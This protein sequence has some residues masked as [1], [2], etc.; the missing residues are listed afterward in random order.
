[1]SK[2]TVNAY[3]KIS[4]IN[5]NIYGHFS[6][7]LGRCIYNGIYVGE[8]SSIPNT[9]GIRNDVVKALKDLNI[10]VLRW[11][12]GCFAD[13]YHWKDG[14]GDKSN[15]KRIINS[16]WGGVIEDNSFGTHEF[17]ELCRQL[18]CE[19][20]ING[21]VGS[22]TVQEM[23]EWIEYITMD[24]ESPMASSRILNGRQAPWG[25]KYFAVGNENWGCGGNMTAERYAEE[26]RRYQ[27]YVRNYSENKI[28]K[29]AC[30][31][32]SSD[33]HWTDVLMRE[34]GQYM[35]GL[36]LHQYFWSQKTAS[37]FTAD[38][39]YTLLKDALFMD[40]LIQI[41]KGIMRRYDPG[42]KVG[43]IVDEWGAWH[44]VEPETNPGFL[45]QQNTLRDA[46][47]AASVL[48]IFNKHSDRVQMANIAQ[49]VNVLQSVILTEG[50]RMAL[51]PTYYVF[52]MYKT[53]QGAALLES[54]V[55]T[56]K[57]GEEN[58]IP[59]LN[60]SASLSADGVMTITLT[61]MSLD[62]A[63][64][65]DADILGY[66]VNKAKAEILTGGMADHNT[67]DDP[68]RVSA[69]GFNDIKMY[70]T[71]FMFEIPP[72]SVLKISLN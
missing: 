18:G 51:T 52:E 61:N 17:M 9:N 42:F 21:N 71:G 65:I 12:G 60:E 36:S 20:Y 24:G 40:E 4:R 13:E 5:P 69:S 7:H 57:I 55:E 62:K 16:N 8:K 29:I 43:L 56:T 31:A 11:P 68:S 38:E 44:K 67:F 25:L 59:N 34:A 32:N 58:A 28:Y 46:V 49:I 39:W 66:Q 14:I 10:P 41:H 2:L 53:H 70:D 15:R 33:Y 26:F 63:Y 1:M 6:E 30:G 54:Y 3:H 27:T 64:E 48:N 72:R 35:D 22:G 45:F 47:L 50:E 37:D 19:P 23:Q